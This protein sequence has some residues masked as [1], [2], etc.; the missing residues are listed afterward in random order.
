MAELGCCQ[1]CISLLAG[2]C[3]EIC[4]WLWSCSDAFVLQ[5]AANIILVKNLTVH[6]IYWGSYM[7]H[8]SAMMQKG[9]REVAQWLSEG[10]ISVPSSQR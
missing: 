1:S 10:K 7:Q 6:G 2:V 3:L 4:G 5:I 9:L 8:H